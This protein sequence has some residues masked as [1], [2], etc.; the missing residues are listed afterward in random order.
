MNLQKPIDWNNH[1]SLI[2]QYFSVGEVTQ[3][4]SER[5]PASGS[6]EEINII[7]LA[8][9]LDRIRESWGAAI[10]VTSWYRPYETNIAVGGVLDSQHITG[11]AADIYPIDGDGQHFEEWLDT[12]WGGAMGYGQQSGRGFTHIDLRG[13]GFKDGPGTIRWTY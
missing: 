13:G 5:I 6:E 11:G 12:Y 8:L 4:D 10:G 9:Q 3:M 2:S 7:A 1:N